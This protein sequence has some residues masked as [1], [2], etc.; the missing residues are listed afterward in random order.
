MKKLYAVAFAA[1]LLLS[2]GH[3]VEAAGTD[4]NKKEDKMTVNTKKILV[5]YYSHSGNTKEIAKQ[6][7]QQT[8]G[9][10]FEIVPIDAYPSVYKEVT[11]QAKKEIN[12]G[13]KPALKTKPGNLAQYDTVFI[14]SPVW[15]GTIAT[16]VTTFLSEN[17]LAGKT[18]VPFV[19]HGGSGLADCEKDIRKL[20]PKSTV[21]EGK[22]FW[23]S[24]AKDSQK[25]VSAWANQVIK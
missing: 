15:W 11:A 22:A 14:G 17:N 10:I 9:D 7:Q 13:Y 12:A 5:V 4:Q 25:A 23:G 8:G 24:S 2:G 3:I 16:P 6:I 1:L 18:I 21:L 19:T 20:A